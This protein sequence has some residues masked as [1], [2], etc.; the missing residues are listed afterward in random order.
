[1]YSYNQENSTG[2]HFDDDFS[3]T[4]QICCYWEDDH[5][6]TTRT[7]SCHASIMVMSWTNFWSNGQSAIWVKTNDFF[8]SISICEGK[9]VIA[10]GSRLDDNHLR[11]LHRLQSISQRVYE[12]RIEV[13]VTC[14]KWSFF[15]LILTWII[16]RVG[17][18]VYPP[19]KN[20]P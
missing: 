15:Q 17:S 9:F 16:E 3:C 13:V 7:W 4:S 2:S 6:I 8:P 12:F 1:M 19:L 20:S 18:W 5:Q 14:A 10:I 11:Y